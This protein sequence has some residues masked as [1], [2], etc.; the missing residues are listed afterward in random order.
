V[1]D[2]EGEPLRPLAERRRKHAPLRDVAGL[3][4]SIAYAAETVRAAPSASHAKTPGAWIDAWE[5]DARAAFLDGYLTTAGRAPFL[6]EDDADTR[7]VV[8][9]FEL[10]KAAY[11]V[12][13]EA[14][15]RPE[16]IGIPLRGVVN[17]AAAI[18]PPRT[19]GAA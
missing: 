17:A 2:F 5:R 15:N 11:E 4:R 19:A 6:P 7:R 3:L 9:A 14:N 10:E 12:V 16:W 8:A 1:I 18:R 13:Y